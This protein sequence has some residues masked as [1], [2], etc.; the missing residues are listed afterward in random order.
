M[1]KVCF[2]D[3]VE[4]AFVAS[5][6]TKKVSINASTIFERKRTIFDHIQPSILASKF[7]R[8]ERVMIIPYWAGNSI[9][10]CFVI[11]LSGGRGGVG[12]G[13]L[14][15]YFFIFLFFAYTYFSCPLMSCLTYFSFF[16]LNILC[17]SYSIC[18]LITMSGLGCKWELCWFIRH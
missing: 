2:Q 10:S 14:C 18:F 1:G 15:H 12:G 9:S 3:K 13:F 16:G 17:T 4:N 5:L 6:A 7:I 11:T 8:I